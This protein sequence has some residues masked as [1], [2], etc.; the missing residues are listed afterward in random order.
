MDT[1]ERIQRLLDKSPEQIQDLIRTVGFD[2]FLNIFGRFDYSDFLL[3]PHLTKA[4]IMEYASRKTDLGKLPDENISTEIENVQD[5]LSK[6]AEPRFCT[7]YKS[8]SFDS[9]ENIKTIESYFASDLFSETP[10]LRIIQIITLLA[11]A[12][13]YEGLTSISDLQYPQTLPDIKKGIET[14]TNGSSLAVLGS[15]ISNELVDRPAEYRKIVKT[16]FSLIGQAM[17]ENHV[18]KVL[19]TV[20]R[21][22]VLGI[23][24][25]D[26]TAFFMGED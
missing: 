6:I 1:A 24:Y 16:G 17:D 25:L 10:L 2:R 9:P 14:L 3:Y 5:V 11:A 13:H 7:F 21:D 22:L 4:E 26:Y 18:Y 23:N 15:S 19:Y 20:Y 12:A 8:L